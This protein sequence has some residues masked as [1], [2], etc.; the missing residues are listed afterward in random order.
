MSGPGYELKGMVHLIYK[1]H[2]KAVFLCGKLNGA[3]DLKKENII[4]FYE[5]LELKL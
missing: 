2:L 1:P 4:F 3:I 5:M